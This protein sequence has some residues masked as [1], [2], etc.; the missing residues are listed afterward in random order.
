MLSDVML[1]ALMPI[2]PERIPL[3]LAQGTQWVLNSIRETQGKYFSNSMIAEL[4]AIPVLKA[5]L[6]ANT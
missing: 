1:S 6:E 3:L 5:R 2:S 4:V